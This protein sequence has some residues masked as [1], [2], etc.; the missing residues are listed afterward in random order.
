MAGH[1]GVFSGQA[2][3]MPYEVPVE[4][5][6]HGVFSDGYGLAIAVCNPIL[7]GSGEAE[8]RIVHFSLHREE[9][10]GPLRGPV[11]VTVQGVDDVTPRLI[12]AEATAG[13]TPLELTILV[14]GHDFVMIRVEPAVSSFA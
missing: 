12:H 3:A 2:E 8:D 14:L 1:A 7:N 13:T 6:P 4:E 10:S 11:R 9:Q 5:F